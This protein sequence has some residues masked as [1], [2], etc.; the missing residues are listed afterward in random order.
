MN[1]LPAKQITQSIILLFLLSFYGCSEN[2]N[3]QQPEK[4]VQ[5]STI[6]ALLQGVYDG[7]TPLSDLKTYGDFGIGTFNELD[8]EMIL[9]DGV[10]YQVK[11]DGK[12]YTP[13][14]NVQT[15]F[16]TV[17]FF[18]PKDS[19]E[20]SGLDYPG[21]KS[22]LDSL[23][24]SP[25]LF[26]AIRLTGTF[27]QVKTRSVPAQ[28]KPYLPLKEIT[29]NQPEFEATKLEGTLMGFYCP[30]FV[31]GINVPG[32]H[33]HFLSEDN[34]FGGHI[35]EFG[36]EKGV[37][38][39]DQVSRFSINLPESGAFLSSDFNKDRSEELK[40]VEGE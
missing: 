28:Q 30:P 40:K 22:I 16:A 26:Y 2:K 8:G 23:I 10:F 14:E 39:L 3:N 17:T 13:G 35:L 19:L 32:Y 9:L 1:L 15:P 37:L 25:N 7:T 12:V 11:A 27:H 36:L 20:V 24:E 6:D 29:D 31:T 34:N 38:S 18:Q 33:L 5:I 21:L 4:I